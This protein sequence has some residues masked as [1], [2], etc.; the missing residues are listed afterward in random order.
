MET[1]RAS[2]KALP[3]I[4][5]N[6]AILSLINK[7]N[8]AGI[9]NTLGA[10]ASRLSRVLWHMARLQVTISPSKL[11]SNL[12]PKPAYREVEYRTDYPEIEE[13]QEFVITRGLDPIT[14]IIRRMVRSFLRRPRRQEQVQL[15]ETSVSTALKIG[16][17]Y[18]IPEYTHRIVETIPPLIYAPSEPPSL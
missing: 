2:A 18:T 1:Q 12:L 7:Y 16:R 8:E 5:P 13:P 3:I 17:T 9:L 4:V 11:P 10:L 6:S 14:G 15:T